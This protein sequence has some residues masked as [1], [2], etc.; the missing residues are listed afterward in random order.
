MFDG[1]R[2]WLSPPV[3][4]DDEKNRVG[5]LLHIILVTCLVAATLALLS[6]LVYGHLRT[7]YALLMGNAV[8]LT[9]FVLARMGYLRIASFIFI[10]CLVTLAAY[11]QYVGQGIH[12]IVTILYPLVIIAAS[13]LLPRREFSIAIVLCIL[14]VMWIVHGEVQGRIATSFGS[15]TSYN[16]LIIISTIILVTAIS[17]RL[18]TNGMVDS[19]LQARRHERILAE[20]NRELEARNAE[21]ERFTYTVSHD[22]KSPLVTIKG[23]LGYLREDALEGN[24]DRLENDL[25]HISTS[26]DQMSQLLNDLLELSRVG[27]LVNP[28]EAVPFNTLVEEASER[29]QVQLD[30]QHVEVCVAPDMP[31]VYVDRPRLVEVLVNLLSN[32]VKFMGEQEKPQIEVGL[33]KQESE[34]IFFVKDNGI[35]LAPR[36]HEKVFGLFERIEAT[37]EGTGV[38]LALVK[39]II[40]LHEGRIWVE[41]KGL[42]HGATFCFTLPLA[43]SSVSRS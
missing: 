19:M 35:G 26:A 36:Y 22:L 43:T 27:R 14:S 1:L 20:T 41:S 15:V 13:L 12:D 33:R 10:L 3:F 23:F 34:S 2:N 40:E 6:S 37:I 5:R 30:A 16:D 17:I 9:A 25:E 18:L 29:V 42:G 28:S 32:A 39:R 21:L 24:L 7:V 31:V 4:E 8:V 11:L 38:G